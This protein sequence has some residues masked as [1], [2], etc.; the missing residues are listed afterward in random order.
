MITG[1]RTTATENKKVL[2]SIQFPLPI[3]YVNYGKIPKESSRKKVRHI[4]KYDRSTLPQPSSPLLL[5]N[6]CQSAI[7]TPSATEGV[8]PRQRVGSGQGTPWPNPVATLGCQ[9]LFYVLVEHITVAGSS[10]THSFLL[11]VCC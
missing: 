4:H 6:H 5:V 3:N 9:V 2:G 8:W 10:S 7:A 11:V 1:A